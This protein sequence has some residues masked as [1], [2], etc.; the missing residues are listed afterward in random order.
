MCKWETRKIQFEVSWVPRDQNSEADAI[1]NGD[2]S[3]LNKDK[4]VATD[5]SKLPVIDLHDLF[6]RWEQYYSECETAHL[7]GEELRAPPAD[8]LKVRGSSDA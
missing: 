6:A 5:L 1:T 3:W 2:W 4:Q 7:V 8:A